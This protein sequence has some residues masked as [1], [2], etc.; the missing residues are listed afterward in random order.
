MGCDAMSAV[1]RFAH[2]LD[3]GPAGE[4]GHVSAVVGNMIFRDVHGAHDE[5]I[6]NVEMCVW[7]ERKIVEIEIVSLAS[8]IENRIR[9]CRVVSCVYGRGRGRGRHHNHVVLN[10]VVNVYLHHL[11]VDVCGDDV[12]VPSL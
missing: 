10:D 11:G 8:E 9:C 3:L 7:M 2:S 6:A 1:Y 12:C 5:A 4:S